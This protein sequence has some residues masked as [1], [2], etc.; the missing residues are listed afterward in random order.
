MKMWPKINMTVGTIEM[1]NKA[2]SARKPNT[3]VRAVHS[4]LG[5]LPET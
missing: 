3:T 1:V 5:K 4:S 2:R